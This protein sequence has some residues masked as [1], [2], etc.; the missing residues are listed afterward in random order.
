[1]ADMMY[2]QATVV[3][4]YDDRY[5]CPFN[6]SLTQVMVDFIIKESFFTWAPYVNLLLRNQAVVSDSVPNLLSQLPLLSLAYSKKI[7]MITREWENM[8]AIV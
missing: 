7:I 4:I 5:V 3:W 8:K 1:M 6:K 2:M